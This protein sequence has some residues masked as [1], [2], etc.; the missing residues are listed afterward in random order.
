MAF[1]VH[2]ATLPVLSSFSLSPT[3]TL[4][5]FYGPILWSRSFPFSLVIFFFPFLFSSS[6]S[7]FYP[8]PFSFPFHLHPSRLHAPRRR[9]GQRKGVKVRW[10]GAGSNRDYHM[11]FLS[12]ILSQIRFT[13]CAVVVRGVQIVIIICYFRIVI[14][15]RFLY[16]TIQVWSE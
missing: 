13:H 2:V 8:S 14:L 12:F 3:S 7:D 1:N 9:L 6:S 16:C 11:I 10:M 15:I 4:I 5:R